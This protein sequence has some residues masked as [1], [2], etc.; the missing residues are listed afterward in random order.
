[1][2]GFKIKK[3][4]PIKNLSCYNKTCLIKHAEFAIY[5]DSYEY[6]YND[7]PIRNTSEEYRISC[8]FEFNKR[9]TGIREKSIENFI[10]KGIKGGLNNV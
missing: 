7:L 6:V 3:G 8:L 5:D 9:I 2:E 10:V 1:M 4:I